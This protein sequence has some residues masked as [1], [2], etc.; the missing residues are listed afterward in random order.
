MN[1]A[2]TNPYL[3]VEMFETAIAEYCGAPYAVA[4]ESCTA[5]IF[6]SLMYRKKQLGS[7]GEVSI[8]ART[9][10]SAPCSILHA[11]GK[12]KFHH[13]QWQG[14]YELSPLEIYD[15]A[16]RFRP[17]MYHSGFQ[18]LS[19]HVKKNLPIGRGGAILTA[20]AEAVRWFKRA[21]F[22]GRAP[23]PLQDDTF[24][25]LG[26]NL[27]LEPA[28]AARGLQLL[29]ALGDRILEDLRVEDQKYADLSQFEIYKQ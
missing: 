2:M 15:A 22:D 29:Q 19:F 8:P 3:V 14:E 9:Y 6:L 28:S 24:T 12:V 7:I 10:P 27:Y 1:M 23:M 17:R 5:A 11:G 16:L 13:E 18:C 26:W 4:V 21:R 25:M 20:D